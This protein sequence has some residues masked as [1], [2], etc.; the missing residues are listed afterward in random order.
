M[1]NVCPSFLCAISKSFVD[2]ILAQEFCVGH[3][4]QRLCAEKKGTVVLVNVIASFFKKTPRN[5]L[6]SG[7]LEKC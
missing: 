7:M 3:E 1:N 6:S 4:V 2:Q 5:H